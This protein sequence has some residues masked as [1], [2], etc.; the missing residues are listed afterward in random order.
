MTKAYNNW[1]NVTWRSL[2][3]QLKERGFYEV[4]TPGGP[5][6]NMPGYHFRDDGFKVWNI[7]KNYVSTVV[8][9]YY[10][11]GSCGTSRDQFVQNDQI[12]QALHRE[13]SRQELADVNVC[14]YLKSG[15]SVY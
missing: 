9:K 4:K 10:F 6:D 3:N 15:V 7:M 13:L 5:D 12:V 11:V 1:F 14:I 8:D 2:P